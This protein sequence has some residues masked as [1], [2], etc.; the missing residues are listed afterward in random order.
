MHHKH[1]SKMTQ[2]LPCDLH[3][4]KKQV[5]GPTPHAS[6]DAGAK[7]NSENIVRMTIDFV[8]NDKINCHSNKSATC[9]PAANPLNATDKA[10]VILAVG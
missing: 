3:D 7:C 8:M 5:L 6:E 1:A 2:T 4:Y 9:A 10:L